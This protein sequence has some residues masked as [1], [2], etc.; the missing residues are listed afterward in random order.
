[1]KLQNKEFQTPN[2][3]NK[4]SP[5]KFMVRWHII[6]IHTCTYA[7]ISEPDIITRRISISLSILVGKHF[8]PQPFFLY[9]YGNHYC[10][11]E[12]KF[13]EIFLQ[14]KRQLGLMIFFRLYG[15]Y[16]NT[17]KLC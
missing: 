11:G 8:Y 15:N 13:C 6:Y 10:I 12:N 17:R 14:Y 1:M 2:I 3:N 9:G 7:C 4:N 16:I 5:H